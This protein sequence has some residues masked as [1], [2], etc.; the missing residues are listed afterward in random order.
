MS[1]AGWGEWMVAVLVS[2]HQRHRVLMRIPSWF[3]AE[4]GRGMVFL[5][6]QW[7]EG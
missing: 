4:A 5:L 3:A 7:Y 2:Y 6:A 1:G